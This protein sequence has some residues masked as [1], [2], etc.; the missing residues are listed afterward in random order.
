MRFYSYDQAEQCY[1][2]YVVID[3]DEQRA[4]I[5]RDALVSILHAENVRVRRYFHP[6]CHRM[7]PYRSYYPNAGLLLPKTEQ[8]CNSVVVFPTGTSVSADDARLVCELVELVLE[9]GPEVGSAL[10]GRFGE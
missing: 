3:L 9:N 8:V 6:G 2:Q 1:F 4:G 7:E 5:S 10:S